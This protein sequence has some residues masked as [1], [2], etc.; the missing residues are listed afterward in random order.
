MTNIYLNQI[1]INL[2]LKVKKL[3]QKPIIKKIDK[4]IKIIFNIK[5]NIVVILLK[6]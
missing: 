1:N 4:I 6:P 5:I 2:A 3:D